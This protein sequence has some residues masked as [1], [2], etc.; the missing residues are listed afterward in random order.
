MCRLVIQLNEIS[1]ATVYLHRN[2][3]EKFLNR[4]LSAIS[5]EA[6]VIFK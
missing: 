4:Y 6:S 2:T 1:I 3:P 5:Y